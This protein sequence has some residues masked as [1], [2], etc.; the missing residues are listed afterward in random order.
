MTSSDLTT[1]NRPR[2][3]DVEPVAVVTEPV[4]PDQQAD[5]TAACVAWV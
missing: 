1:A 3:F 5:E 4:A 2:T